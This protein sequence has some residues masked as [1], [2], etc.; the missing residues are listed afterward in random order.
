MDER[1]MCWSCKKVRPIAQG[2]S[3]CNYC[4]RDKDAME[5]LGMGGKPLESMSSGVNKSVL[6]KDDASAH[7]GEET[8][9]AQAKAEAYDVDTEGGIMSKIDTTL[10]LGARDVEGGIKS[11]EIDRIEVEKRDSKKGGK[12]SMYVL[13]FKKIGQLQYKKEC[14]SSDL[15]P[16]MKAFNTDETNDFIGKT[17]KFTVVDDEYV[18]AEGN[19]QKTKRVRMSA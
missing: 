17:V 10:Y 19:T 9:E 18:D 2:S 3:I 8:I 14:M 5:F 16:L 6:F 15:V 11:A 13:Y 7:P 1:R 12:Y 4:R